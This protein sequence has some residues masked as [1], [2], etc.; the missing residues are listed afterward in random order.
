SILSH[1]TPSTQTLLHTTHFLASP[2]P[3]SH[4]STVAASRLPSS[5][6]FTA[7]AALV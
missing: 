2:P 5:L 3:P 4:P 7:T 1:I 6:R